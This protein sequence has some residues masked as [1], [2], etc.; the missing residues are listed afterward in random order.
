[1]TSH[2]VQKTNVRGTTAVHHM[3]K[4]HEYQP[5]STPTPLDRVE[6]H[7]PAIMGYRRCRRGRV[8]MWACPL[9]FLSI[10]CHRC[11]AVCLVCA[12][13]HRHKCGVCCA[14]GRCVGGASAGDMLPNAEGSLPNLF[15]L[16]RALRFG[17]LPY[18]TCG[19]CCGMWCQ[20]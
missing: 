16:I 8:A 12:V 19:A 3:G 13:Y 9:L 17:P 6:I 1:M 20:V 18:E 10:S 14:A 2:L 11:D 15:S 7:R 5:L 4:S